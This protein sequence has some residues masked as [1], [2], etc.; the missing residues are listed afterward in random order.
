MEK[1]FTV[2]EDDDHEVDQETGELY[3]FEG[4]G[5]VLVFDEESEDDEAEHDGRYDGGDHVGEEFA[6]DFVDKDVD[7][8]KG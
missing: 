8:Q 6:D 2:G 4:F 5:L 7:Q 3:F 1:D